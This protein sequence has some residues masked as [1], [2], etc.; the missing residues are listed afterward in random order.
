MGFKVLF[1]VDNLE[2]GCLDSLDIFV[3]DFFDGVFVW[4]NKIKDLYCYKIC[5]L[6][7][8]KEDNFV[9]LIYVLKI[10]NK[11]CFNGEG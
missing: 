2:L 5:I 8:F 1:M 7:G 3:N 6:G 4:L 11:V 10:V 9:K